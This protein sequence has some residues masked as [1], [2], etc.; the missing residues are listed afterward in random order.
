MAEMA[1]RP[2]STAID[3]ATRFRNWGEALRSVNLPEDRP[4]DGVSRWLIMT[5]AAVLPMTL[6]SG[7]IGGLLASGAAQANW[8]YFVLALVG[9]LVAHTSNNL[10]NDYFDLTS[11]VDTSAAPRA[12]YAPHP[13][14]SGWIAKSD[15]RRAIIILNLADAL[16]LGL[17]FAVRGWP[18]VAFALAGLLVSVFYVAPP[19]RLKHRGLGEPGVFIVWGPLMV[20]G[21]Y[22]VTAGALPMWVWA[23][24]LPYAIL[25]T[26]VLIGKHIDKLPY[27]SGQQVRTLPVILGERASLRLNQGLMILFYAVTVGLVLAGVYGIGVLLVL[28]AVPVL[29]RTLEF[30]S[31]PKPERQP[32]GYPVWPL[33]YVSSAF[34]HTRRAGGLLVMGLILSRAIAII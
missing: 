6:T 10:I 11:G 24:S 1:D 19:L 33:W 26:T 4:V 21:T 8:W 3:M 2:D 23:A 17:L 31:K 22:Y 32:P 29:W 12:L 20:C 7:L 13:V 27:D 25:V 9:L 16:I 15:L 5:R 18:V 14:L 30:Y 28:A 34:I